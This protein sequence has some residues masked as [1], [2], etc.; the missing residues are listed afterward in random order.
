MYMYVCMYVCM[1][2]CMYVCMYA[3]MYVCMHACM[4]VCMYVW[5]RLTT[6]NPLKTQVSQI[7]ILHHDNPTSHRPAGSQMTNFGATNACS[8]GL[9]AH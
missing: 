3:C 2:V 4:Y 6:L 8:Y 5:H 9:N 7:T 1:C